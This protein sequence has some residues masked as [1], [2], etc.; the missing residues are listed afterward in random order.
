MEPKIK[1]GI[2]VLEEREFDILKNKKIGILTNKAGVDRKGELTWKV[3][4]RIPGVKVEAIFA[5]V[6]GLDLKYMASETF[7]NDEVD[8]IPIYSVYASNTR[9]KDIWLKG[10]DAV[11]VDLQG[12]GM[13]YYNYWAFMVYMMGA[14]FE[15]NIEIIVLDRPNPLGGNYVGGPLMAPENTSLW[16]PIAGMPLF[17]GMTIGEVALYCKNCPTGIVAHERIN[18]GV[19]YPG[20]VIP[21]EVLAK[22]KLTVI[23]MEGWKRSMLW[24]DTGLKWVM[25]SPCIRNLQSVYEYVLMCIGL[26]SSSGCGFG[27]RNFLRMNSDWNKNLH[28]HSFSLNTSSGSHYSVNQI[29]EAAQRFSGGFSLTTTESKKFPNRSTVEIKIKDIRKVLPASFGLALLSFVQQCTRFYG[30][31]EDASCYLGALLGDRELM[32]WIP[33]M[34][35]IDVKYFEE[36]WRKEA[37]LYWEEVKKYRLYE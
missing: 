27:R 35:K 20:I 28:F 14:C 31:D 18:M 23:P 16:G 8:E 30:D 1:L 22:G 21:P 33:E 9:P 11:V 34:K 36:K 24:Q 10:L 19:L 2:D 26:C 37:A 12:V 17:H 6:H 3:L 29:R 25:S 13:R 15:N 5:P 4:R 7:C 32:Q